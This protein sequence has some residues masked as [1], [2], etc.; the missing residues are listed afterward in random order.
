MVNLYKT[1]LQKNIKENIKYLTLVFNDFFVLALIFLL[2]AFLF[3]YAQT[4]Q[5]LPDQQWYYGIIVGVIL[6]VPLLSGRLATML[7][8]ADSYYLFTQDG[9]LKNYLVRARNY[10]MLLPTLMIALVGGLAFPFAVIKA[11]FTVLN[12]LAI[13]LALLL[14]KYNQF[15]NQI[16]N[17]YVSAKNPLSP[18]ILRGLQIV[19][20][21]LTVLIPYPL[22]LLAEIINLMLTRRN[23][24]H[25]FKWTE[26][27]E[28]EERRV[29]V[30]KGF[31][32]LFTDVKDRP[33]KIRRR[34][35]LDGFLTKNL[36]N[37]TPNLFLDERT[38]LRNPEFLNL[39][40]RMTAFAVLLTLAVRDLAWVVGLN[41]LLIYLTLYQLLPLYQQYDQNLMFRILPLAKNAKAAAFK[42]LMLRV[43][44][45]QVFV[46]GI[47]MFIFATQKLL[48]LGGIM[49]LLIF[50]LVLVQLYLP[51]KIQQL[52]RPRRQISRK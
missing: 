52:E 31:Y 13:L 2:G 37:Q 27:V 1:R 29:E 26:A 51:H 18:Q 36:A 16:Q 5:K 28:Y 50:V 11:N 32:S 41:L 19:E 9:T 20:L 4:L 14:A 7:Q 42:K 17:F 45:L 44:V 22:F 12:Y 43:L 23:H 38:L 33:I 39:L 40:L 6:L 3:W 49:V 15:N 30:V 48:I 35:Y 10:S 34:K 8:P 21:L 25:L 24:G 47:V 46:I